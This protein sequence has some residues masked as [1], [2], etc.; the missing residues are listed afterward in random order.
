MGEGKLSGL[1]KLGIFYSSPMAKFA[2]G[3]VNILFIMGEYG[4]IVAT[5]DWRRFNTACFY[6]PTYLYCVHLYCSALHF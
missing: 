3:M 6:H 1:Q 2:Y 5:V 4:I